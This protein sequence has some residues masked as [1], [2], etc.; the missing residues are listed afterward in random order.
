M[1]KNSQRIYY[2]NYRDNI[3]DIDYKS[4][5]IID[6]L[7]SN[8]II[9]NFNIIALYKPIKSEVNVNRL[10]DYLLDLGKIICLPR[11][12]DNDLVFIRYQK[13]DLLE[14]S[15]YGVEEP[16]LVN[17]SIINKDD[18][19]LFIVPGICFDKYLSRMGY[20]KGYYDRYLKESNALK[21]A[22]TYNEMIIDKI[23]DIN[24]RD[25]KMNIIITEDKVLH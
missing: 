11:V 24:D 22:L 16:L 3:K 13:N 17:E 2:S 7:L 20:G 19:E 1:S 25:I 9:D 14:T 12:V 18:I 23:D 15:N 8:N 21:V 10:I 4:N 6:N 5:K